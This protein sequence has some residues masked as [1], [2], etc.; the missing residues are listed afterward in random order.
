MKGLTRPNRGNWYWV[1]HFSLLILIILMYIIRWVKLYMKAK[2]WQNAT[3][4]WML[5]CDMYLITKFKTW[6]YQFTKSKVNNVYFSQASDPQR[7][8]WA[9]GRTMWTHASFCRELVILPGICIWSLDTYFNLSPIFHLF[10]CSICGNITP[11]TIL[12]SNI[13]SYN[14]IYNANGIFKPL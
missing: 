14:S 9:P 3:A 11:S 6:H 2:L 5:S 10:V 13:T 1:L 12:S 8:R 4:Y 7:Y